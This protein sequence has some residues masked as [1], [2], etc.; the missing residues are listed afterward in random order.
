M[1]HAWRGQFPHPPARIDLRAIRKSEASGRWLMSPAHRLFRGIRHQNVVCV[2]RVDRLLLNEP[3]MKEGE[4]RLPILLA[5][6]DER[7]VLD[8]T[9]LKECRRL[10][11][12]VERAKT[13]GHGNEGVRVF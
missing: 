2:N 5:H 4:Q 9:R 12:F 8:F 11:D 7:K 6:Q 3:A 1:S 13:S 10:E